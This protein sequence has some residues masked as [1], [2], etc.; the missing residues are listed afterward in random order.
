MKD[1]FNVLL[2]EIAIIAEDSKEILLF[3]L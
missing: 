1:T 2:R 3:K